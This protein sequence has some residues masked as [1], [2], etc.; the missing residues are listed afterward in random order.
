MRF[1]DP[2][3]RHFASRF[4]C[5]VVGNLT[6]VRTSELQ[7]GDLKRP[8]YNTECRHKYF[9]PPYRAVK[10]VLPHERVGERVL[11][12]TATGKGGPPNR[13]AP[14]LVQIDRPSIDRKAVN[15]NSSYGTI[16]DLDQYVFAHDHTS[17]LV[18]VSALDFFEH[19]P[20][21]L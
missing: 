1:G 20:P 9:V 5:N 7:I 14:R 19:F 12:V 4:Q 15:L 10:E 3:E 17:R 21:Q 6:V 11:E 8:A 18:C 16:I 13:T 2:G